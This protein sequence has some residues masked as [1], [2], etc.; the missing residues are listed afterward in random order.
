MKRTTAFFILFV[1]CA[2]NGISNAQQTAP[3]IPAKSDSAGY[4]V[5]L[6]NKELFRI[7]TGVYGYSAQF[8][9]QQMSDRI[10]NTANDYSVAPESIK[11]QEGSFGTAIAAGDRMILN[12][13]D[14]DAK[15]EGKT[16]QE[17]AEQYAKKVRDGVVQY[18][19]DYSR[20]QIVRG[21]ALAILATLVVILLI[22]YIL[23]LHGRLLDRIVS[24]VTARYG[25][26][27]EDSRAKNAMDSVVAFV[28]FSRFLILMFIL[29]VYLQLVLGLLPWTRPFAGKIMGFVLTPVSSF[30]KAF[31]SWLPD[32]FFVIVL[33]AM[34]FY[35]LKLV[36]I[37]FKLIEVGRITIRGFEPEWSKTTY[38]I[39]RILIIAF[40]VVVAFPYL[41]GSESD[42]FKGV[43]LFIGVLFSLG[44]SSAIA[45]IIAGIGLTYRRAFRVGDL[46]MIGD[47]LG[48]VTATRL[49]VTHLRTLKN[50]VITVPN[51][52]LMNTH[53][54]NYSMLSE[55][56]GLILHTAVTIGYDTPWRQIEA[57][58]LMAAEKTEGILKDP[59]P[60]VLQRELQDFYV[61]YE[62]NAFTSDTLKMF[63]TYS[64]LH[65]NIQDA[66]N[67]YGVQ[68]MS[69]NYEAD[70]E[71]P[72]VVPKDKWFEAPAKKSSS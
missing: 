12:V 15:A 43:S 13:T 60:F 45:N 48:I 33:A 42:A 24:K 21:S 57:L 27:L 63:R 41:P 19:I 65:Q 64:T 52:Q 32:L 37:V 66:F 61:K 11:H 55:E 70:P 46:V 39:V 26:I 40:A 1:F 7:K 36:Q 30:W 17:L 6:D 35:L 67:E 14:D 51:S 23:K 49:S 68:I 34:V 62:L 59:P 8:R 54:T 20:K 16:R 28:N 38:N 58:L 71:G 2:F 9:A 69:P 3:A 44:S 72:K 5:I 22:R 47:V 25:K 10:Q 29:L 53:V 4:P 50:E 31:V 56:K 18:R